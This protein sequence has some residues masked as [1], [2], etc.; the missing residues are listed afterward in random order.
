MIT[1]DNPKNEETPCGNMGQT[2]QKAEP[3]KAR[4]HVKI[5]RANGEIQNIFDR[6]AQTLAFLKS[7]G[8]LGATRLEFTAAGWAR[9]V[10]SY[11]HDLRNLGISIESPLEPIEQGVR[12]SRYRLIEPIEILS[13]NIGGG[14]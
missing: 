2:S 6:P 13:T 5:K 9:S 7:V 14:Q 11:I 4:P 1:F 12:V 3:H 8:E 10:P